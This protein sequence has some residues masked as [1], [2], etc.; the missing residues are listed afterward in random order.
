M[1]LFFLIAG[2]GTYYALKS[3]RPG[4]YVQE[5]ALRL[6]VPLIFGML[7]IVV[8]QAYFE[9]MSHSI[10]LGGYHFFQIYWLYL[11]SLPDLE[12][13]HLWFLYPQ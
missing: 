9:A 2:V 4:Q 13:F 11:Q 7:V 6:L 5:R 1:P 10:Q 3:R 8:P 12:W